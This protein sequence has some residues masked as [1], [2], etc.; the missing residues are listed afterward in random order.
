MMTIAEFK[1]R[2]KE[3]AGG[4]YHCAKIEVSE[5]SSGGFQIEYEAYID[6]FSWGEKSTDPEHAL[7]AMR[8][9]MTEADVVALGAMPTADVE[10]EL[11]VLEDANQEAADADAAADAEVERYRETVF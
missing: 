5:F 7:R 11:A 10:T 9:K 2:L 3:I 8:S 6:G 1:R 4:R